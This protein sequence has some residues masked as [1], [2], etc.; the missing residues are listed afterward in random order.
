V[1]DKAT[2]CAAAPPPVATVKLAVAPPVAVGVNTTLIA[3]LAPTATEVPQVDVS[4]NDP[5]FAPESAMLVIGNTSVPV[6]VTVTVWAAL[7]VFVCT[8]PNAIAV[9]DT[10]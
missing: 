7:D 5:T 2:D 1:P 10:V 4:E 9:G 8:L 6:F 3:Q